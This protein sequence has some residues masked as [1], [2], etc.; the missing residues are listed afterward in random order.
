MNSM[1]I[2]KKKL[3]GTHFLPKLLLEG[4][5]IRLGDTLIQHEG[6]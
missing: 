3:K 6:K 1:G 2:I 5:R 4:S